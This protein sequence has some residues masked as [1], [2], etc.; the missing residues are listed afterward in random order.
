M[1][2]LDQQTRRA[3]S[4]ITLEAVRD[5]VTGRLVCPG[6]AQKRCSSVTGPAQS[7]CQA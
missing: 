3:H 1:G 4:A 5:A 2:W 6:G 7:T